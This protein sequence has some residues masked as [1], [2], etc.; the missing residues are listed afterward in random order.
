MSI[1]KKTAQELILRAGRELKRTGLIART[2]G[3]ISARI[4]DTSF[5][6]TPSGRSYESL[7]PKDLVEVR[8]DDLSYQGDLKPSSEMKVHAVC[9]RNRPDT[10]FV[11]HTHQDYATDLS[12]LGADLSFPGQ[13][14]SPVPTADYAIFGSDA[15]AE[16]VDRALKRNDCRVVLMRNHGTVCLGKDYED[17]FRLA[18][19][20]EDECQKEYLKMIAPVRPEEICGNLELGKF[21]EEL[22]AGS[23]FSEVSG[24]SEKSGFSAVPG[25]YLFTKAPYISKYA[26]FGEDLTVYVD[27]LGMMVGPVV[28]CLPKDAFERGV[29]KDLEK[30][31]LPD[32][33]RA[34]LTGKAS[35][36]ALSLGSS[37]KSSKSEGNL[38]DH[39]AESSKDSTSALPVVS[40]ALLLPGMG[41]VCYGKDRSEAEAMVMVLDK[42]CQVGLLE[43]A[44]F[45]PQAADLATRIEEH[46]IYVR[47]YAGLK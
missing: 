29:Q 8:L 14:L 31:V 21:T 4:S 12:T 39:T 10:D 34:F 11:I 15:L 1:D 23:D 32:P 27:D 37:E 5:L 35:E 38:Q 45:Q 24:S 36:E 47:K 7:T 3:N 13:S 33:I 42:G 43:R 44:G 20:L 6:I 30:K 16:N 25:C 22:I 41:A 26:S 40:N 18:R 19:Q 17:A 46:E 28:R 9:Y 2:W